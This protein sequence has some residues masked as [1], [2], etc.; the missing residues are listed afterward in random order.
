MGPGARRAGFFAGDPE[1]VGYLSEVR[2]HMG[3]M[4]PGPVQAAAVVAFGDDAHVD[5]QR[6]RYFRR[7]ERAQ[8]IMAAVGAPCALPQGGFY[9]W[10]PAPGGDAWGLA[11]TLAARGGVLV[12]PGEAASNYVR[13]AVVQSDAQLELVARRLGVS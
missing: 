10:A 5:E 4:V 7:L 3:L 8:Q 13:V 11:R 9:L 6:G 12:S 1:L 2:K